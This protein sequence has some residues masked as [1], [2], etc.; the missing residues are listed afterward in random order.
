MWI[1]SRPD[2]LRN[3]D[4]SFLV[5][6]EKATQVEIRSVF[7]VEPDNMGGLSEKRDPET[8]E[9]ILRQ[10]DILLCVDSDWH[11]VATIEAGEDHDAKLTK[12]KN[13][14]YKALGLANQPTDIVEGI[15]KRQ[16]NSY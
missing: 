1:T 9:K 4:S 12:A 8:N 7:Q 2:R 6:A 14:L 3:P 5:N 16:G 15:V 11:K 10:T 13:N